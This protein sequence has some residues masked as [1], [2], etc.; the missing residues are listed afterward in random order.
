[1]NSISCADGHLKFLS[2]KMQ[3]RDFSG[4]GND[5]TGLGLVESPIDSETQH[6]YFKVFREVTISATFDLLMSVVRHGKKER[7]N[8]FE[9]E[10]L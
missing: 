6:H 3:Q 5:W 7:C 8:I 2:M 9:I 4:S 10:N 1:M